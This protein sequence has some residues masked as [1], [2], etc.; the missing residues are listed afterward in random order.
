MK[1]KSF[2]GH[3]PLFPGEL[4]LLIAVIINSFGVVLMLHSGT[5]I[6]AISSVPFAF[7]KVLPF[8]S[9]GTWTYIF[10][11]LLV[12][13]LMVLRRHF[14]PSYLFSF[15]VGFVFSELLDLYELWVGTF[16][17]SVLWSAVYF[18]VSYFLIC[19]GIALSNHCGLPII[20][21]DL[22]P[23]ELAQITKF[24]YSKIKISFDAACLSFLRPHRRTWY[25]NCP[26]SSDHGQSHRNDRTVAGKTFPLCCFPDFAQKG[27]CFLKIIAD[28]AAIVRRKSSPRPLPLIPNRAK[29]E[30]APRHPAYKR[31]SAL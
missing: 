17:I 28:E 26:G 14:V 27:P 7:S 4:A 5:G 21:T 31:T 30:A 18:I 15:L 13:T 22:F 2:P 10:Q 1:E 6:S 24:S 20:P 9:L 12:L 11:G 25:R 19:T 29:R 16:P 23:R 3:L 8:F